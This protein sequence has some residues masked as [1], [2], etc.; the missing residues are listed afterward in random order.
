MMETIAL[1]NSGQGGEN[2]KMIFKV[3]KRGEK[4]DL[5]TPPQSE[6]DLVDYGMRFDLTLPLARFYA[7]NRAQ[8]PLPFKVIQMGYV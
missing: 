7:N 1:L 3:L 5:T 4:L 8:L 2:Q 6:D